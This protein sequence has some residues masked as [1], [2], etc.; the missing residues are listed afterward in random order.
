MLR[1]FKSVFPGIL[2]VVLFM[3]WFSLATPKLFAEEGVAS[4]QETS[5]TPEVDPLA[6]SGVV[7]G[8]ATPA[9]TP[10]P[11]SDPTPTPNSTPLPTPDPTPAVTPPITPVPNPSPTATPEGTDPENEKPNI[12]K[13]EEDTDTGKL[14]TL[15]APDETVNNQNVVTGTEIPEIYKVG[16][17]GRIQI[18][19]KNNN[20]Q[21][22][23]FK[24][25]DKNNN[26]KLDYV[27]WTVPH[28]STQVFEIIY[29]SKA[30]QLDENKEIISDIYDKVKTQDNNWATVK[31]GQSVRVTFQQVLDNTK[32]IT[33]HAR[34][35]QN[36]L[37][38]LFQA[39][40]KIEVYP[41]YSTT[42]ETSGVQASEP[43]ATF[44][45]IDKENTY[46]ILLKDLKTP[47]DQFDLRV[48]NGDI[49][50]D[51]I[52]DPVGWL[53]NWTHRKKIT[54][55]N[56]NVDADLT[57]FPALV[58]ITADADL[59]TALATGYDIR[60]TD[61]GGSTLLSYERESW[62]GG[63]GASATGIFWVKVPTI[64]DTVD[65]D[66]YVYYGKS[67][68]VDGQSAV[69]V[70]DSNYKGVWHM[71]DGA[72]TSHINDSTSN[73]KTG[74]KE[75]A[76]TPSQTT[77]LIGKAQSFA[78]Q[79]I[80]TSNIGVST[81]AGDK[82]TVD[83][84]MKWDGTDEVMPFGFAAYDLYMHLSGIGFNSAQGDVYG[85]PTT[86]FSGN[87][88]HITAV[89]FNGAYTGNT[90][91]Y[92]NGV[93]QTLTQLFGGAGSATVS[94]NPMISGW[95]YNSGYKFSGLLDDVRIS[96]LERSAEWIKFEYY[97]QSSANAELTFASQENNV[98]W[99]AG[100]SNRKKITIDHT[101]VGGG[102]ETQTNFPVLISLTGLSG[103]N[104][105][106]TDI[107]FTADDGG[108]YLAREI[109]SYSA[110]ALTAWVKIPTLS[111]TADTVIY[112]YY[113][114]SSA[115]EPAA[116]S[117]YG[118]QNV[119][120]SSFKG[121]WHLKEATGV[122]NADSTSNANTGTP[123]N[124]PVQATGKVD[125]SLSF[126]GGDDYV[127]VGTIINVGNTF[128]VDAWFNANEVKTAGLVS[129][130]DSGGD[131]HYGIWTRNDGTVEL[132]L[133][134]STGWTSVSTTYS[135]NN[136]IHII[137]TFDGT[138][139]RLYKNGI[140]AISNTPSGTPINASN[141]LVIGAITAASFPFNG[142][143]DDTRVSSTAR[144][145]G[146]IATEYANQNSPG[147]F[148]ATDD[149]G[150]T[151][152][153]IVW[154]DG[155]GD[156]LW[157]TAG[158]WQGGVV[159]TASDT[160]VFNSSATGNVTIDTNASVKGINIASGYTG[161]I[162]Q[163]A[164]YT[165][166]IGTSGFTQAD[167]V[168]SAG[169]G[170]FT[171]SGNWAHSAGTFTANSGT[172]TLN[173]TAQTISGSTTFY[174]LTKSVASADTLTF[175]AGT[176]QT[177]T[178]TLTLN[179]ASGQLLSLRSSSTPTQW[180]IDPQGTKSFS[181]LDIQDSNNINAVKANAGS[182]SI[183]S[184]N[185]TNWFF[186]DT[187]PTIQ[188]V[189]S[190][191]A[192]NTYTTG[193]VIDIDLTFSEP[194]TLTGTGTITLETGTTDQTCDFQVT[195]SATTTCNYTVQT[196]D[197]SSDLTVKTVEG[198]IKDSAEN[199]MTN[200]V[201][202][203][204]L[205]VNKQIVIDTFP[206]APSNLTATVLSSSSIK[207]D[208]TD[209]SSNEAGFKLY[210]STGT[211]L[212]TVSTGVTTYTETT[213]TENTTYNRKVVSYNNAGNSAY[214]STVSAL[215]KLNAPSLLS[216]LA[217]SSTSITW[218][219]TDNSGDE[220]GFK[221]YDENNDLV[222]T[223]STVNRTY[224][225]E[226]SLTKGTSYTRKV[227][228]Y[229]DDGT[230]SYSNT[231]TVQ[232]LAL[233][234]ASP[235]L[236][237]PVPGAELD[238]LTPTFSFGRVSTLDGIK[239][240]T[241]LIYTEGSTTKS[242]TITDLPDGS[243]VNNSD[244]TAEGN[245]DSITITLKTEA[246]LV[247]G[248][249]TWKVRATDNNNATGDSDFASFTIVLTETTA[250]I[251]QPT[252][253]ATSSPAPLEELA[254][255][256]LTPAEV[257]KQYQA[258]KTPSRTSP[259]L[260]LDNLEKQA[261]IR[262]DKQ[263]ENMDQLLS[264]FIPFEKIQAFNNRLQAFMQS[265]QQKLASFFNTMKN[266][267]IAFFT[268]TTPSSVQRFFAFL[269]S[270]FQNTSNWWAELMQQGRANRLAL[271][272]QGTNIFVVS[273][274]PVNKV[275]S[276]MQAGVFNIIE[277]FQGINTPKDAILADITANQTALKQ[278]TNRLVEG[279]V[280]FFGRQFNATKK[281]AI[282]LFAGAHTTFRYKVLAGTGVI[283]RNTGTWL[284][285]LM[286]QGREN[287]LA[288]AGSGTK[289]VNTIIDPVQ[290]V[291]KA[292]WLGSIQALE[293][294]EGK[295]QLK[296]AIADVHLSEILNNEAT[297]NWSTNRVTYAKV[298]YGESLMYGEEVFINDYQNK[299]T[300]KLPNLKP[301][302]KYYFEIIVTDL[303]KEQAYDAY[304]SFVTKE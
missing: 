232:T 57:D 109:E 33:I 248:P 77:G 281:I 154:T 73:G 83:F 65:T 75:G 195:D 190:D 18:K 131:G 38:S 183:S 52:V 158:N 206:T 292:A 237:T 134:W 114:N 196:G 68:A 14:V 99:L 85:I 129:V 23:Q 205:A 79:Q 98:S 127:N 15:S 276:S 288:L 12:T 221:L 41:V 289:V 63:A 293:V 106:G 74:T 188:S 2:T 164:S 150:G 208:W 233:A 178:N 278:S 143:L 212:A 201:P 256:P 95:G 294:L 27:E 31:D 225:T 275:V 257:T 162:T 260:W 59:A 8:E 10:T 283:I 269:S 101:K 25:E 60:F 220:T 122:N 135:T 103:I 259:S 43:I 214:S 112:M 182:T 32:D 189:S 119:W 145:A 20:D 239:S 45:S 29:I 53:T 177:I 163:S 44:Q 265:L 125:G 243:V 231:V 128:S 55:A 238:T 39:K 286:S 264:K 130:I 171:V 118:S 51:Y 299:Q 123:T 204:N 185:N 224:Y 69:N 1:T 139:L 132:I 17:E 192:N 235:K 255:K 222:A 240:Y 284:H 167:G 210:S 169:A 253:T 159:P 120:D 6:T 93:S 42:P 54:I 223:I 78:A 170:A 175:T 137:G 84:W 86:G 133:D 179:G 61:S 267:I 215:T 218:S 297:L 187:L 274:N 180:S 213:L 219:W 81:V 94:V 3:G 49:D 107:R 266:Q 254:V 303:Q 157:S 228:S 117:T 194:V 146:W 153:N 262:A 161:T 152:N 272:E 124:G 203:S 90:K 149:T 136:W 89:F 174:N 76:A 302:T 22:M 236:F 11:T 56:T 92:V 71:D 19:W 62:S 273:F 200:F 193:T 282:S 141:N 251:S 191:K 245:Q 173:G 104:A 102:T 21:A 9:S 184:G 268:N 249:H 48:I 298:N 88:K 230:S 263:T 40:P 66:I 151:S 229:N 108:T 34:P 97:N 13:T 5:T 96:N 197:T 242:Y 199:Q 87:W 24:A 301:N 7:L 70:W 280:D 100:W 295:D 300:I 226:T 250:V 105:N 58:S 168:F 46:Q 47:T 211:L 207:W 186:D 202:A 147:T 244:Y 121:V 35:K 115:T 172:V 28:L 91:I 16:Q 261:Q 290:R 271:A 277:K 80:S 30:F 246:G 247:K 285:N 148:Y 258:G 252:P 37:L 241:L 36:P 156:N 217:I 50:F 216:G 291:R 144:S 140:L 209:N 270:F 296:L 181:Y 113:G 165:V 234:P 304:Y 64:D 111:H 227:A 155:S 160:A 67:D 72:D 166:T 279:T 110:G 82:T 198:T 26:G 176:T 138:T 126:D 142:L 4:S 287:R 116:N